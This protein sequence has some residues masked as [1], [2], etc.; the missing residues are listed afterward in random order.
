M[1]EETSQDRTEEPTEKRRRDARE[2]GQVARSRE[3]NSLASL[4]IGA[5]AL[6]FLGSA[7]VRYLMDQM[8]AGLSIDRSA[9]ESSDRLLGVSASAMHA[10]VVALGPLLAVM[11]ATA[12][13]GPLAMGGWMFRLN[14]VAPKFEKLNPAKGL[15]RVFG[16]QGLMELI[17][18]LAK[19]LL[20]AAV[21]VWF[22]YTSFPEI[23]SL[24]FQPRQAAIVHSG[25]MAG[26]A[27][28]LLSSVL[29]VIAAIDV[30]FQLYQHMKNLRMT[31][32][33]LKDEFKE[34]DGNPEIK[35][36]IRGLQR[37]LSQRRMMSDLAS[38]DVVITNP[39]HYAVALKYKD[40]AMTA[41]IVV[42][43]GKGPI[44]L[45]IIELAGEHKID[46]FRAPPLARALY[47]LTDLQQE[48]P[49][50]LYIAV[51]Q[52]LAYV[53]QLK[54]MSA[55]SAAR[56]SAPDDLEIPEEYRNLEP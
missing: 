22:I 4:L 20:V 44:A 47:A 37:E 45:R 39:T 33:E 2:K 25:Q 23:L 34:T 40:G 26:L 42:A 38:A 51:A 32:Q 55:E 27:F 49:A 6:Y 8:I 50:A 12:F 24:G 15:G 1:A 10:S 14:A 9:L 19:F 18:A 53:Y 21:A 29:V 31:K 43:K 7:I 30:P 36:R 28:I 54:H 48:I 13:M 41:P 35:N 17:K 46:V 5:A 56:L 11:F 3:L 16:L 52:V